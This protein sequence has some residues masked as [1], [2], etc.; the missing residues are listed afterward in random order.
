MNQTTALKF[1]GTTGNSSTR[2]FFVAFAIYS[3]TVISLSATGHFAKVN[4][5]FFAVTV[6]VA[7][8]AL[9]LS[10]FYLPGVKR[11]AQRLGPYGLASFHVWRIPAALTFLYYGAQ[12]WLPDIFVTLA[13]WGDMLAG[14][15]AALV[16]LL[17]RKPRTILGFHLVG[18]TDFIIAV[19]TGIVLNAVAPA[20]MSN[21]VYLPVALIPLIGVPVSGATHI[22]SL[23]MLLAKDPAP[24]A[25]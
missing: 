25:I 18:M 12:G 2:H 20:S 22:A 3:T 10:Y 19:G 23:H 6:V 24:E 11:L 8:I 7:T 21:V 13:G 1:E 15:L 5:N 17:P 4:T 16:L 9:T 14:V